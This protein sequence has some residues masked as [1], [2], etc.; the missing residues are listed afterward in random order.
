MIH[1]AAA[2]WAVLVALLICTVPAPAQEAT[3]PPDPAIQEFEGTVTGTIGFKHHSNWWFKLRVEKAVDKDGNRVPAM[4]NK[5]FKT[6]IG[7]W[8]GGNK[9]DPILLHFVKTVEYGTVTLE[10]KTNPKDGSLRFF[11]APEGSDA[12]KLEQSADA[13]P[14]KAPAP[15]GQADAKL[16]SLPVGATG[17]D[18]YDRYTWWYAPIGGGGYNHGVYTHPK[19]KDLVYL[20]TDVAGFFRRDPGSNSWVE[21]TRAN[22]T[23]ED[24]RI[25]LAGGIA[26]H[27]E[28]PD[29][30]W[31]ALS[32]EGGSSD[33]GIFHSTDRGLT[34]RRVCDVPVV[35]AAGGPRK[36]GPAM[37]I[38]PANPDVLYY[39]S[40]NA[41]L[42][43]TQSGGRD[44]E[45]WKQV[46]ATVIPP[47]EDPKSSSR[48]VVVLPGKTIDSGGPQRS[49]RVLIATGKGD[50]YLTGDGGQTWNSIP[51][52]APGGVVS[53][54]SAAKSGA[55][56]ASYPGGVAVLPADAT[57]WQGPLSP[58]GDSSGSAGV[59]VH[60][61]NDQ[62]VIAFFTGQFD[63]GGHAHTGQV[64]WQSRDGGKSWHNPKVAVGEA[65]GENFG[66][67]AGPCAVF[68]D[69]HSSSAAYYNDAYQ[70]WR[71]EDVWADPIV[72]RPLKEGHEETIF[73]AGVSPPKGP[74]LIAGMADIVGF[75]FDDV[76]QPTEKMEFVRAAAATN[77]TSFDFCEADPSVIY[78]A[79]RG[80]TRQGKIGSSGSS[81]HVCI[82][83]AFR[84]DDGGRKWKALTQPTFATRAAENEA[85]GL[86]IAVSATDPDRAVV[87][88]LDQIRLTEDGGKTWQNVGI[89]HQKGFTHNRIAYDF[90]HILASD[91]VN[92][93][94]FYAYR[95]DGDGEFYRST[96]G[97]KTFAKVVG[98]SAD[99]PQPLE[100]AGG[101]PANY[102]GMWGL[103]VAAAPGIEGEVWIT[104]A[105]SG[106]FRSAGDPSA[107]A[108]PTDRFQR[109]T[110][111]AEAG[112]TN[113]TFGAP[114]GADQP[115]AVY[116]F[117]KRAQD[118]RWGLFRSA[119]LGQSWQL[120]SPPNRPGNWIRF[121]VADR[122]VPGAVYVGDASFGI[123]TA[124]EKR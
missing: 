76:T 84:S 9:P 61:E 25:G 106:V 35:K 12:A 69:P 6:G 55:A 45:A 122:Q 62:H 64:V 116:V 5:P 60:P 56:Y 18:A 59:A 124:I 79:S 52:P 92:G 22:F 4:E 42:W 7:V 26:L 95:F 99:L 63:R 101:K 93:D 65:P 111:F 108:H 104:L 118:G 51:L 34:L 21:T 81:A 14:V 90:R 114:L 107:G 103:K 66:M 28:N 46:P 33:G 102:S 32:L 2:P 40:Q 37:A 50:I 70:V 74:R 27:P 105:G 10:V 41:G 38:D 49:A 73:L 39:M 97:G 68:F 53:W 23:P 57:A 19:V 31:V 67:Y 89:E 96:D 85:G 43:Y 100:K 86:K 80:P 120:I 13:P 1:N 113:V 15:V 44:P 112:P 110:Y 115:P 24:G 17:P 36:F 8:K 29:E 78:A 3:A 75:V 117:G 47:N 20:L 71:T 54:L 94:T 87:V 98:A 30:I 119:D 72:W 83:A 88:Q 109:I 82:G 77:R 11:K 121:L 16:R 123:T 48:S 91:R 58:G